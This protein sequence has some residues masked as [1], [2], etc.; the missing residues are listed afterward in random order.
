VAFTQADRDALHAAY[1]TG[2]LTVRTADGR[3]VTYR[4]VDDFLKL[5]RLMQDDIAAAAGQ[6]VSALVR[7]GMNH[8]IT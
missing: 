4:S 7:V 6:T 8:G 2:A 5:D 3:T 1:K